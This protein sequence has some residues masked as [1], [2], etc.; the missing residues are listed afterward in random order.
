MSPAFVCWLGDLNFYN[1][2][3]KCF[4]M[5]L[6]LVVLGI[7]ATSCASETRTP[8]RTVTVERDTLVQT[9]TEELSYSSTLT[10]EEEIQ[11]DTLVSILNFDQTSKVLGTNDEGRV[12]F[13]GTMIADAT[14]KVSLEKEVIEVEEFSAPTSLTS[15]QKV[16][17][18]EIDL[19]K[20][21]KY[22]T[23]DGMD[24]FS[25]GQS[26]NLSASWK[27]QFVD[28]AGQSVDASHVEI[29]SIIFK[30]AELVETENEN[31]MKVV[32]NYVA[33]YRRTD[34]NQEVEISLY[35]FYFQSKK[36]EE[37]PEINV[38]GDSYYICDTI[39][40][41]KNDAVKCKFVVYEVTPNSLQPND[42]VKVSQRTLT[43][44]Q[45]GKPGD[46]SLY[47]YQSNTTGSVYEKGDVSFEN[48]SN[49]VFSWVE[50]K[51]C[52]HFR[53]DWNS[54]GLQNVGH[55]DDIYVY[56]MSV[57]VADAEAGYEFNYDFSSELKVLKNE[58]VD[59]KLNVEGYLGTRI[60]T[61]AGYCNGQKYCEVTGK[62]TLIQHP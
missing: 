24:K 45:M 33:K 61:V 30:S 27:W 17:D 12:S 50:S 60:L 16:T 35:P 4:S 18:T 54:N 8:S 38:A 48:G 57:K 31:V 28:G 49:G 56:G 36:A 22:Q 51:Q 3:A 21:L 2:K 5:S 41:V 26:A 9:I 52:H 32:L 14:A 7:V 15:E 44:A 1:M 59:E 10:V 20:N 43:V 46:N 47:V 55:T 29:M 13:S 6:V 25:D 39:M 58:V 62:V 34:S 37:K 40:S 42:T 23:L 11:N 19:K 53:A